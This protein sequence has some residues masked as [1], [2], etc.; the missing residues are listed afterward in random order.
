MNFVEQLLQPTFQPEHHIKLTKFKLQMK[1]VDNI[2]NSCGCTDIEMDKNMN[3][4]P[5]FHLGLFHKK[6]FINNFRC[7]ITNK[8][9]TYNFYMQLRK[10]TITTGSQPRSE[11]TRGAYGL[12]LQKSSR[13]K[14]ALAQTLRRSSDQESKIEGRKWERSQGFQVSYLGGSWEVPF[15]GEAQELFQDEKILARSD[16]M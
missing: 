7:Q 10:P 1:Q 6:T 16:K 11:T 14:V 4:P 12:N 15:I 9:L 5:H 2:S 13:L 3:S 8:C